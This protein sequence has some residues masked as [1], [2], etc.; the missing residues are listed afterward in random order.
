MF[1]QELWHGS[2]GW[3]AWR[4]MLLFVAF[5]VCPPVWT[6]F[7]LPL[8]HRYNKVNDK[9]QKRA[10]LL[11]FFVLTDSNYKVHVVPDF[12]HLHDV[13]ANASWHYTFL[14]CSPSHPHT[15]L[16]RVGASSLAVGFAAF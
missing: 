6:V 3:A 16:V 13:P 4:T 11:I 2:L 8:G 5:I 14:P 15:L 9:K 12:A 10:L 1:F 7:S